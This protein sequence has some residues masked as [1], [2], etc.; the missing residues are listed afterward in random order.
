MNQTDP[1]STM[2]FKRTYINIRPLSSDSLLVN[3]LIIDEHVDLFCYTETVQDE[4]VSLSELPPQS[5]TNSPFPLV[6][7]RLDG[8]F[9]SQSSTT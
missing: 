6:P 7:T 4:Y 8:R 5:H 1:I 2:N 3:D 9:P